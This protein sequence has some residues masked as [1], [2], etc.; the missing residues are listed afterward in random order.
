MRIAIGSSILFFSSAL[1]SAVAG[2]AREQQERPAGVSEKALLEGPGPIALRPLGGTDRG[3]RLAV[4]FCAGPRRGER[5]APRL[6]RFVA[7]AEP[8]ENQTSIDVDRWFDIVTKN[9]ADRILIRREGKAIV[10]I[11]AS[12]SG[13]GDATIS[14]KNGKWPAPLILRLRLK[15]LESLTIS[16]GQLT[17]A[18]SFPSHGDSEPRV[19]LEAAGQQHALD[20]HSQYWTP[21]RI[22][23]DQAVPLKTGHFEL[24]PPAA[25]TAQPGPMTIRWIDFY[26]G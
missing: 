7:A 1:A 17:L 6:Y 25:F 13:I 2:E 26:R 23:G 4:R 15:G 9:P 14:P 16:Q 18:T 21:V 19:Y 11:V 12:P 22:V 3:K 5:A 24:T 20:E 8:V 10:L